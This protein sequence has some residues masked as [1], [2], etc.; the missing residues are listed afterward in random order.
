M[1]RTLCVSSA[2]GSGGKTLFSL[3]LGRALTAEG[4]AVAPFKKGPDY[5]DAAWLARACRRPA[6]NLDLFFST[7]TEVRAIFA[8]KIG[9]A[10]FALIEGNRGLYDGLDENGEYSTAALARALDAPV[11]L[12]VD[13]AKS[14]RTMAAVINGLIAFEK[15]LNFA[16]VILNRVGSSRHENALVKAI[17]LYCDVK[18]LGALPR[19]ADNPLP[20]RHMGLAG[21]REREEELVEKKLDF[22]GEF[23][24]AHCD[25]KAITRLAGVTVAA[26]S[27]KTKI[28]LPPGRKPRVGYARDKA[29]W[30]YYE[31][32][33]EALRENGAELVRLSLFE[34]DDAD[35]E[36]LDGLY[37]GGGFPEDFAAEIAASPRLTQ[38]AAFA[39]AN[40]PIYAECGGLALLC[41]S[42]ETR[43]E[44]W[45]MAGVLS[46]RARMGKKPRGL[47]YVEAEVVAA[48]PFYAKGSRIRGHEFHYS[49]CQWRGEKPKLALKLARGVGV[50]E[51]AWDGISRGNLWASYA[52][53]YAPATP[54]WAKNFVNLARN[55]AEK[56]RGS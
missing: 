34:G 45:P 38:I 19:L 35:W 54:E 52:H 17:E 23:V 43:G 55:Y 8:Q 39:R 30:F 10:N 32:N 24:Q 2:S 5:I 46:A 44:I 18:P 13:C 11:L 7:P 26:P 53:V 40:L 21:Q 48:N 51:G 27:A 6:T 12:C 36:N 15:G 29:I 49:W 22:L 47:G 56:R 16:G 33:L 20:E 9:D 25:V 41:E 14:T 42:L 31:E 28:E 50:W 4:S 1:P 3:G 37:L